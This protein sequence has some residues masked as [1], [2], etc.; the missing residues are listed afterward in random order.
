VF[1]YLI[2]FKIKINR[3]EIEITI[4]ATNIIVRDPLS[5][6]SSLQGCTQTVQFFYRFLNPYPSL[7][8]FLCKS[9][10]FSESLETFGSR[11]FFLRF[12]KSIGWYGFSYGFLT[13]LNLFHQCFILI[14][15][16]IHSIKCCPPPPH[17]HSYRVQKKKTNKKLKLVLKYAY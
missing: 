9:Q 17:L 10:R 4:H 7:W 12:F 2:Y 6:L 14:C 5:S 1:F 16:N 13:V 8:I 15:T 11:V 3:H